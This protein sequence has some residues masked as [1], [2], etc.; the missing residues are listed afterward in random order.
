MPV[1]TDVIGRSARARRLLPVTRSSSPA[2]P[3]SS[4]ARSPRGSS[5]SGLP[6][7]SST[8]CTPRSTAAS[9]GRAALPAAAELIVGDVTDPDAVA[10]AL[11]S[12][13]PTTVVHLAAE[14]GTAQS[15]ARGQPARPR[16]RRRD[17]RLLDGIVGARR[18]AAPHR[19]GVVAG[20]LRR[21]TVARRARHGVLARPSRHDDLGGRDGWDPSGPDGL[22]ARPLPHRA[23]TTP[24]AAGQHL[25]RRRSSPRNTCSPAW[26]AATST[27]LSVLRLQNVYGPG[28]SLT[29]EY[30]GVLA[31]SPSTA[32]AGGSHRRVRGRRRSSRDFVYVDDAGAALA[33]AVLSPPAGTRLVDI[34]FGRST[35]MLAVAIG[36]RWR[37]LA[38]RLRSS[39]VA[40]VTATCE[41]QV[42]HRGRDRPSSASGRSGRW[43]EARRPSSRRP[44]ERHPTVAGRPLCMTSSVRTTGCSIGR[45]SATASTAG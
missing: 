2:G 44:V 15:L 28:Q 6:V 16:Q 27:A 45:R 36:G 8:S 19:A 41:R 33:A 18:P 21:G 14:T 3:G 17:D 10:G 43:S 25:R 30:A 4:G 20:G 11:T 22:P 37:P 12:A 32:V 29:N 39:R 9:S 38:R 34:G 1:A 23:G 31:R 26:C 24:T 42:A 40:S 13:R 5:S 7:T 35:S